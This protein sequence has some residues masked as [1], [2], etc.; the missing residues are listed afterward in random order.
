MKK[1]ILVLICIA[2]LLFFVAFNY[3][4]WDRDKKAEDI[5]NLKWTN[6]NNISNINYLTRQIENLQEEKKALGENITVLEEDIESLNGD[7]EEASS[8]IEGLNSVIADKDATIKVI[9][10]QVDSDFLYAIIERW[11]AAMNAEDLAAA[12]EMLY[13]HAEEGTKYFA[14]SEFKLMYEG[15]LDEMTIVSAGL[16]ED[17]DAEDNGGDLQKKYIFKVDISA[18]FSPEAATEV[19]PGQMIVNGDNSLLIK[20]D[21]DEA[22]KEW[23]IVN[24]TR[25]E[26]PAQPLN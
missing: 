17:E 18:V 24:M 13:S 2:I 5:E 25:F 7:L 11:A 20:I 16:T 12:H 6:A 4:I 8:E 23:F 22:L 1:F 26:E 9:K 14:L 10:D 19:L 3:L 15:K 21:F